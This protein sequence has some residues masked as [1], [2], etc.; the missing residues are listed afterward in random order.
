MYLHHTSATLTHALCFVFD[1]FRIL[2]AV[3]IGEVSRVLFLMS[4]STAS[5][6]SS[7]YAPTC[8]ASTCLRFLHCQSYGVKPVLDLDDH[9]AKLM[10]D[11]LVSFTAVAPPHVPLVALSTLAPLVSPR[12]LCTRFA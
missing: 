11:F 2:E 7:A 5:Q 4:V 1:T 12:L 8:S 10:R 9:H 6:A 3:N